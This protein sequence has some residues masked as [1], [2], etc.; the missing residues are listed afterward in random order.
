MAL[1]LILGFFLLAKGLDAEDALIDAD[2]GDHVSPSASGDGD[3]VNGDTDP[4]TGGPS[5]SVLTPTTRPAAEVSVLVANGSGI[6]RAAGRVSEQ[7]QPKGYVILD[8]TNAPETATTF[9]F[10]AE[11]YQADA[12]GV[13]VA[14]G[15]AV[16]NVV[17]MSDPPPAEIAGAGT[18]NVL[19]QLGPDVVPSG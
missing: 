1:A 17:P 4:E 11:G 16:A 2:T 3:D 14:L 19:V 7:L 15:V 10:Y 8:P 12:E 18:A 9:V 6:A 5:V 13:A